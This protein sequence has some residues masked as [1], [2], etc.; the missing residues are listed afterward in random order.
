MIEM[1]EKIDLNNLSSLFF[2]KSKHILVL[3]VSTGWVNNKVKN[4]QEKAVKKYFPRKFKSFYKE[5][6]M[7]CKFIQFS[8]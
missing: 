6:N 5:N 4:P 7:I 8:Y 2:V 1:V 3:I